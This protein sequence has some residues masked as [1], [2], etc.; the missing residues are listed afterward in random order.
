M[1]FVKFAGDQAAWNH[2]FLCHLC[3]VH[4]IAVMHG[5][6]SLIFLFFSLLFFIRIYSF[7]CWFSDFIAIMHILK[8]AKFY[9]I[10][11]LILS[12]EKNNNNK[13]LIR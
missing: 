1:I 5:Y 11:K 10:Y 3:L 2:E 13:F 4:Q 9:L 8:V 12:T 7:V 6:F